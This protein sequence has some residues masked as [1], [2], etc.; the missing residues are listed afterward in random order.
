MSMAP[1][2][3]AAAVQRQPGGGYV[4]CRQQQLSYIQ[5]VEVSI[6]AFNGH[7]K[8]SNGTNDDGKRGRDSGGGSGQDTSF[9]I[10]DFA[11]VDALMSQFDG[12][13]TKKKCGTDKSKYV[14][15]PTSAGPD[16]SSSF[17]SIN[18]NVAKAAAT[19]STDVSEFDAIEA[20]MSS[21][22]S[23]FC[24]QR[25][26]SS[27]LNDRTSVSYAPSPRSTFAADHGNSN[28]NAPSHNGTT[29]KDNRNVLAKST[30]KP[31]K[32]TS[33]GA[34]STYIPSNPKYP[35]KSIDSRQ[36]NCFL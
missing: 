14:V 17:S 25:K 15:K 34:R 31:N 10:D 12:A 8:A 32:T 28:L 19:T 5:P 11:A 9:D 26:S 27:I 4:S 30:Y 24:S 7:G 16:S 6:A 1:S 2:A 13:P 23:Q 33:V 20:M 35:G 3:D 36:S 18:T 21:V 29:S 22:E